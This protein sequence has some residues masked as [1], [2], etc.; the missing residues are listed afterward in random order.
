M[1]MNMIIIMIMIWYNMIWC[2]M[3][4]SYPFISYHIIYHMCTVVYRPISVHKH[5][6]MF[7]IMQ[8]QSKIW[9]PSLSWPPCHGISS[10]GYSPHS[11][12]WH[13]LETPA[14]QKVGKDSS[15]IDRSQLPRWRLVPSVQVVLMVGTVFPA[16]QITW[17]FYI[18]L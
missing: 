16:D 14:T 8:V 4:S 11:S 10:M 18:L 6:M 17:S 9:G 2:G 1:I 3:L 5:H 7:R 15:W 12:W 13:R